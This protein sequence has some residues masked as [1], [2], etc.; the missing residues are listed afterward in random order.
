M[1]QSGGRMAGAALAGL[2]LAGGML[3]ATWAAYLLA[4]GIAGAGERP[5]IYATVGAI[6]LVP[7]LLLIAVAALMLRALVRPGGGGASGA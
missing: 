3:I 5:G 7:A 4:R 6:S 2:I 1:G